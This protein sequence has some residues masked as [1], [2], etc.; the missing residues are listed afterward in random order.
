M[1]EW[2]LGCWSL[3]LDWPNTRWTSG[4]P[5]ICSWR[6]RSESHTDLLETEFPLYLND[7]WF[8]L[9]SVNNLYSA[10]QNKLQNTWHAIVF[11]ETNKLLNTNKDNK[12]KIFRKQRRQSKQRPSWASGGDVPWWGQCGPGLASRLSVC[13]GSRDVWERLMSA[14]SCSRLWKLF[15]PREDRGSVI[16]RKWIDKYFL[17][18]IN[19]FIIKLKS[20]IHE[21]DD[22]LIFLWMVN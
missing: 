1:K 6:L 22:L 11:L 13:D 9:A 12:M 17:F 5:E 4:W 15:L 14:E 19:L 7:T 16:N 21:K 10:F 8:I 3:S 20:G 18:W 2:R